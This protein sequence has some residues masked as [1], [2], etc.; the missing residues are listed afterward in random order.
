MA[1]AGLSKHFPTGVR[2][3]LTKLPKLTLNCQSFFPSLLNT[4]NY[5]PISPGPVEF[6]PKYLEDIPYTLSPGPANVCGTLGGRSLKHDAP[7]RGDK[8]WH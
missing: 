2:Q 4:L 7:G 3:G 5:R 6:Y 1:L 8:R